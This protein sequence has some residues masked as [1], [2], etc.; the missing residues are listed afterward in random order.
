MTKVALLIGVS[1]YGPGFNWLPGAVKDVEA[2]QRVL[3]HPNMGGFAE[4][5]TLKNPDPLVMQAAIAALFKDKV[6]ERDDLVLLFFSG[7]CV[8]DEHNQ[9][10]FA[11]RF[12][13]KNPKGKLVKS[14]V[15]PASFV[16]EIMSES[17]SRQQVMI[18]DCCFSNV[19]A[20]VWS[21]NN[22]SAV[23]VKNQLGGAGRV[24]LTASTSTQPFFPN[25]GFELSTYTRYLVEGIE[26]GAA[27]FDRNQSISVDELHQYISRKV[28]EAADV[29]EPKIYAIAES[30]NIQLAQASSKN[31]QLR[32][33]KNSHSLSSRDSVSGQSS[34][35]SG[36][37]ISLSLTSR[38]NIKP[39]LETADNQQMTTNRQRVG[40]PNSDSGSISTVHPQV[41]PPKKNFQ[42]L[43]GAGIITVL[44][45]A[46]TMYGISQW[47][48]LQHLP[49]SDIA[50]ETNYKYQ[51][52]AVFEH[53]NTVWSLAFSLNS[54]FLASSSED[55]TI[56]IWHLPDSKLLRTISG[57]HGDTIW[58]VAISPDGQK[59]IGGSS[60]RTI[61]I[62][63]LNTGKL[64]RT[65][66]GHTDIVWSVAISPDGQTIASGSS[67]RTIKIWN[68]NTGELLRILAG[69][70][71]TVRSVAISPDG[72]T[73][74]SGSADNTVKIWNL[75]T[76]KL[77][78]TLRGHTG[79]I[80]SIAI[81]PDGE[82]VASG[83]NDNT[84]KL[85]HLQTGRLLRAL[86]GHSDWVNT[87]AFRSDG[88]VL[89][90]GSEDHS[91]KLWNPHTGALL[92]TL[93]RHKEDVYAVA[94]SPDGQTLASGD[95]D[96]EIKL[97]R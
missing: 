30:Y 48:H 73:V 18:L 6:C 16:Q 42:L 53:A 80:I 14:T 81:S 89:V 38:Q 12:T 1:D 47:Q 87:V 7:H 40:K 23:D 19:F 61:K 24:I 77:I 52:P 9:L 20:D 76:G 46:G 32:F 41:L 8:K 68:L 58:S 39:D 33:I 35:V 50:A 29:L 45:L 37:E 66:I 83:S 84:I 67:D 21:T 11:T 71:D 25:K 4:V 36:E 13:C 70:T 10:Y 43:I 88:K 2:M 94:I 28:E 56:K 85:W 72:Q 63:N 65:L 74:A 96:G 69:H 82:T 91:I 5:E 79:R 17:L 49:L 57:A 86:T 75:N 64:L 31:P 92:H 54:Q 15:V 97:E 62:W 90:S 78:Y 51:I 95:K 26:T 22:S 44:A 34:V 59:L 55:K 60:D 93:S 27:D 3:Q